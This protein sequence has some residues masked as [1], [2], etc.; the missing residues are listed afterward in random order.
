VVGKVLEL[1]WNVSSR[2]MKNNRLL[3]RIYTGIYIYLILRRCHA[4]THVTLFSKVS[5]EEPIWR[6][7]DFE[8]DMRDSV[9]PLHHQGTSSFS[10]KNEVG[11]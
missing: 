6:Y 4:V 11:N 8:R 2:W 1:N 5:H 3:N 7:F 9:T 10:H